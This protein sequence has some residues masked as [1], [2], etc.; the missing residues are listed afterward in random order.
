[1][2]TQ[3]TPEELAKMHARFAAS[4]FNRAWNGIEKSGRS[5]EEEEDMLSAA[6]ASYWHWS[7]R[8]DLTPRNR[9]VGYWQLARVY[10]LLHSVDMAL[11]FAERCIVVGEAAPLPPFFVGYGYEARARAHLLSG[12]RGLARVDLDRAAELCVKVEAEENRSLLAKDLAELEAEL[13]TLQ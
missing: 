10:A 12:E 4:C 2:T 13:G 3:P 7:Q 1:M 9:S 6:H 11:R 5:V 8:E